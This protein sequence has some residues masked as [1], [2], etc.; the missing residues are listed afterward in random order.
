MYRKTLAHEQ[1][2]DEEKRKMN[3]RRA[4]TNNSVQLLTDKLT[5]LHLGPIPPFSIPS[6][7]HP[8]EHTIDI[9]RQC[10]RMCFRLLASATAKST[11]VR[12]QGLDVSASGD[13]GGQ[14]PAANG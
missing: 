12:H 11:S 13:D 9:T 5:P 6:R 7:V 14:V 8:P 4:D 1:R 3:S 10:K 2:H